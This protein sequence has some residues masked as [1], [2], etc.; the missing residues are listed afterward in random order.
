MAPTGAAVFRSRGQI[1]LARP[2][3]AA[4][5]SPEPGRIRYG[6][7][8]PS[9][10]GTPLA[11]RRRFEEDG[12]AVLEHLR[13]GE[14]LWQDVEVA[15]LFFRDWEAKGADGAVGREGHEE[16]SVSVGHETMVRQI[17]AGMGERLAGA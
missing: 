2:P 15:G 8:L 1:Q 6:P 3:V 13:L 7:R 5:R 10:L 4:F 12:L 9:P 17:W 16:R 14:G 11:P